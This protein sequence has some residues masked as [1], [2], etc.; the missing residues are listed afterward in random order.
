MVSGDGR[1]R[2]WTITRTTLSYTKTLVL[3]LAKG[4]RNKSS[5]FSGPVTKGEGEVRAW[6]LRINNFFWSS[7]KISQKNV[8]TMLEKGVGV[9]KALVVGPLKEITFFA[10]SLSKTIP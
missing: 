9:V 5:F 6:L 7:K 4:S 10:A 8:A 2:N 3:K 1:L